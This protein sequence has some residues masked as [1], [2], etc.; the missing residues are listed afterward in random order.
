MKEAPMAPIQTLQFLLLFILSITI[1]PGANGCGGSGGQSDSSIC[2][3][4]NTCPAYHSCVDNTCVLDTPTPTETLGSS[5][6]GNTSTTC[7]AGEVCDMSGN[8][9]GP[10]LPGVCIVDEPLACTREYQPVC[11]CDGVTYGNDCMRRAARVAFD[12]TG[13]CELVSEGERCGGYVGNQCEEG[14]ACDLSGHNSCDEFLGGNCVVDE[15]VN[16]PM[17]YD[18]VC[19]CDNVTYG[20]DCM[21]QAAFAALNH[22]G[23][24]E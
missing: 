7:N 10:E 13:S 6:G 3:S 4:D 16:C 21:R 11:G 17:N 8:F 20:N 9:C 18:P 24:C 19:G 15:A 23:A 1:L 14:L 5:C 22:T 12:R 2:T